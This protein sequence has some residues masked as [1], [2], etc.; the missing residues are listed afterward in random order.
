LGATT[1]TNTGPSTLGGDLGVSPG[2]ALTGFSTATIGGATHAGD[3]PALQA[4]S[5]LSTAWTVA[6]GLSATGGSLGSALAGGTLNPGVYNASSDLD[7]SG[8]VT[9]DGQ[10]DPAAVFVFQVGSSLTTASNTSIVLTGSAQACNVFWQVGASATLG[11]G[12][13][14]AGTVM[15]LQ[16]ITVTTGTTVEGRALA[17]N[18]AVTLDNNVFTTPSCATAPASSGS[19]ASTSPTATSTPSA[20]GA[21]S[22]GASTGPG[23]GSTPSAT[24]GGANAPANA[25]ATNR[26]RAAATAGN[27]SGGANTT[28]TQADSGVAT[29]LASTGVASTGWLLTVAGIALM[30]GLLCLAGAGVRPR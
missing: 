11:T 12:S 9:L 14:F 17:R 24:A 5:D 6:A 19:S 8:A 30:L 23:G 4:E 22:T 29:T 1:V 7:L 3:A 28:T 18:G 13:S 15:A 16:S 27:G 10:G 20:S 21:P 2:L 25:A 26:V